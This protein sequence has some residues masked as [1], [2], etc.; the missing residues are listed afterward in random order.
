M[1]QSELE[2][3]ILDVKELRVSVVVVYLDTKAG[4]QP[5]GSLA[6][7][8][9]I[10][11]DQ[12]AEEPAVPPGLLSTSYT[13]VA[14]YEG[15]DAEDRD[16]H[17]GD[18]GAVAPPLPPLEPYGPCRPCPQPSPLEHEVNKETM[19]ER[20]R[21]AQSGDSYTRAAFRA[22]GG[23]LELDFGESSPAAASGGAIPIVASELLA[24]ALPVGWPGKVPNGKGRLVN[25]GH[26]PSNSSEIASGLE[27]TWIQMRPYDLGDKEGATQFHPYCLLC[28]KWANEKHL[29]SRSHVR[30]RRSVAGGPKPDEIAEPLYSELDILPFTWLH[31]TDLSYPEPEQRWPQKMRL[32]RMDPFVFAD[33][34]RNDWQPER[35]FGLLVASEFEEERSHPHFGLSLEWCRD[36]EQRG[37]ARFI[38]EM[39][40]WWQLRQAAGTPANPEEQLRLFHEAMLH[41]LLPSI[42]PSAAEAAERHPAAALL[43]MLEPRCESDYAESRASPG[44]R[45]A[46]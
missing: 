6:C 2:K 13:Q 29:S 20:V 18:E 16:A 24:P 32:L 40:D 26:K 46:A 1:E 43:V 27:G 23:P 45:C 8:H 28:E 41:Q 5:K 15:R 42:R 36:S 7:S 9:A 39:V 25:P 4:E 3:T 44:G 11:W 19:K 12:Y 30:V 38:P 31:P 14:L 34:P 21:Y 37:C 10:L 33:G 17:R 22:E 35:E